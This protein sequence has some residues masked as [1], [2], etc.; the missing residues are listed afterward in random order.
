MDWDI[1][2]VGKRLVRRRCSLLKVGWALRAIGGS[3]GNSWSFSFF[4]LSSD[5]RRVRGVVFIL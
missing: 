2:V 3:V 4:G 5:G 1:G